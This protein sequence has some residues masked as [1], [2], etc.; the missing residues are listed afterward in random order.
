VGLH[1]AGDQMQIEIG[2][3]RG[4]DL[5]EEFAEFDRPRA[6]MTLAD[7]VVRQIRFSPKV[8]IGVSS[9]QCLSGDQLSRH[10][11]YA[12]ALWSG[13]STGSRS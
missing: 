3:P 5:I 7:Q 1:F 9:L 13:R 4:R 11:T 2:S 10:G 8:S 12:E 6:S